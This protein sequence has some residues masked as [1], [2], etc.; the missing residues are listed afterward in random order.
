METTIGCG[1][2]MAVVGG[3]LWLALAFLIPALSVFSVLLRR[4]RSK[5]LKDG[6]S[7]LKNSKYYELYSGVKDSDILTK[8]WLPILLISIICIYFASILIYT[9]DFIYPLANIHNFLL[10][11]HDYGK[12]GA[13]FEETLRKNLDV[14]CFAFLGWYVW[15]VSTI[16]ARII[17]LELIAATFWS[18]LIRLVIAV[19][20]A[21]MFQYLLAGLDLPWISDHSKV[22]AEAI[23]FGVGLFPDWA[24]QTMTDYLQR[25]LLHRE[26]ATAELSLDLIQ[27]VSP[28]RKLR[29]SEMGLDNCQNLA[30]VNAMELYFASN[31]KL[32]EVIDWIGQAQLATLVGTKNFKALLENGYRNAIDFHRAAKSDEARKTLETL[33]KFPKEQLVDLAVGLENSPV[34]NR[35][36]NLW[37]LVLNQSKEDFPA[38]NK[39]GGTPVPAPAGETPGTAKSPGV[40]ENPPDNNASDK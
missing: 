8:T 10:L 23:G 33:T 2:E 24:L 12:S 21:L 4:K 15:T 11:G 37:N 7:D 20:V 39:P 36:I 1:K 16:F 29:L 3:G 6:F 31:L 38:A 18:I 34:F 25:R 22:L 30:A 5:D 35:L 17:T 27:G 28:F 19:F 13:E 32:V 14:M 40:Q 9:W 26:T